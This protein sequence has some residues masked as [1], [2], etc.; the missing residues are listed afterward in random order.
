MKVKIK[1]K[2]KEFHHIEYDRIFWV[3]K[4]GYAE[5][6]ELPEIQAVKIGKVVFER[7]K[8]L[9]ADNDGKNDD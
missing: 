1:G 6:Q 5:S 9:E 7:K 3:W 8:K 4:H 2:W